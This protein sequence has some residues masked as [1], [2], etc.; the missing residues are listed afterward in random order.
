MR[1]RCGLSRPWTAG[2]DVGSSVAPASSA[3]GLG[4][5]PSASAG[6]PEPLA[7]SAHEAPWVLVCAVNARG[8]RSPGRPGR[9]T[10]CSS[11]SA[12]ATGP[13]PDG[14]HP[15]DTAVAAAL[16]AS[17]GDPGVG[18]APADHP[19]AISERPAMTSATPSWSSWLPT[20]S[21]PTT[22]RSASCSTAWVRPL[23]TATRRPSSSRKSRI[24]TCGTATPAG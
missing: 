1:T 4:R 12:A 21:S 7:S 17:R 13:R 14:Q 24:W 20:A 18:Q 23:H 9:S 16:R 19:E 22:T 15:M 6:P 11:T 8:S 5:P 2:A 10:R 3:A